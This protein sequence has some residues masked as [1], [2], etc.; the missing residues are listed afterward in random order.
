MSPEFGSFLRA[1]LGIFDRN[2][3]V[4]LFKKKKKLNFCA[5]FGS[6]FNVSIAFGSFLRCFGPILK[7]GQKVSAI[8]CA[9]S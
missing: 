5:I 4:V 2:G 7:I 9:I 8:F 6:F 3:K 1:F